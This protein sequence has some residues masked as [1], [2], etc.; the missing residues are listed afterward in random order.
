MKSTPGIHT[1]VH[2]LPKGFPVTPCMFLCVSISYKKT[3]NIKKD[4]FEHMLFKAEFLFDD[5][6]F[7]GKSLKQNL[8]CHQLPSLT[9]GK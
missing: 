5:C 6:V 2:K 1:P 8:P 3:C 9:K 4:A 7:S